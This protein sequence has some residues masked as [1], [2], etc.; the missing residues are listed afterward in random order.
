MYPILRFAKELFVHRSAPALGLFETHVSHHRI[1]PIDIDMWAELNNGRTLTLY[2]LG[3]LV[4][5]NRVGVVGFMRKKG[6][7]GTVAGASVRYRR[8]VQM[9]HKVQMR[10]RIVGW[11]AKFLYIEQA[12]FRDTDGECTSHVLLRTAVTDRKRMI[13]MSEAAE[14]MGSRESPALPDWVTRWAEADD[15]R[16]WPPMAE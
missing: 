15:H 10:S 6:W 4:L 2:D 14:A 9:F 13:P 16:P 11:D 12:M 7:V 8:R 1:W 5:F 3:R